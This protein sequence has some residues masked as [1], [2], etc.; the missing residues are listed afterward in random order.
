[1][2]Q[3]M[4]KSVKPEQPSVEDLVKR[5]ADLER[6]HDKTRSF[7]LNI[8]TFIA[9]VSCLIY[10]DPSLLGGIAIVIAGN[11]FIPAIIEAMFLKD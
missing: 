11:L 5:L 8:L 3:W 4:T 10:F 9:V 1:V 7:L 6:R 2:P